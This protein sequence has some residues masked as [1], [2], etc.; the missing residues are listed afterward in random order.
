MAKEMRPLPNALRPKH[1][2]TRLTLWYV[3]VLAG[4]LV[5]SWALTASFLFL[6]MRSQLD[7]YAIQD[8]ETVE[9]LLYFDASGHLSCARTI[10]TIRNPRRFWNDWWRFV[11]AGRC[12][13]S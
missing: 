6:Q 12:S 9:G 2:R 7:H 1:V 13:L 10:T 4:V 8:I 3:F 11:A 5:L